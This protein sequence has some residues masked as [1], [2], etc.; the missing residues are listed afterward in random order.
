MTSLRPNLVKRIERLPKPTN[1]AGAMQPLFEAISNA[2]HSTQSRFG[3][4]VSDQGRVVVIPARS[5]QFAPLGGAG[6]GPER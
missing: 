2:I 4:D 3:E 5:L 1:V 6:P